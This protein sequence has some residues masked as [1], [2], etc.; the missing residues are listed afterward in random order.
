MSHHRRGVRFTAY[1]LACAAVVLMPAS[2]TATGQLL[3]RLLKSAGVPSADKPNA[4]TRPAETEKSHADEAETT[5][6]STQPAEPISPGAVQSIRPGTFEIHVRDADLR[7]VLQ[8]LSTQGRKNIIATRQVA[9]TVTA[10]LYGVTFQEAL[11]AILQGSGYVHVVKGNFIY[12]HTP[13]ELAAMKAAEREMTVKLF[14]LYYITAADAKALIAPVLSE[15]GE[16][17]ITPAAAVGIATSDD[18]AGGNSYGS[19]DVIIVREY[20]DKMPQIEKLIAQIDVKPEQVLIEATIL[21]ATLD[22][23]NTLGVDF[24]MLAGIDF[25]TMNSS[26][27]GLQSVSTGT[28]ATADLE[29]LR[30]ATFRSDFNSAIS[31]G[32]MTIGFLANDVGFFIRALE[33]VTDTT[34]LANPK[35]LVVNKQ[36]GEI[37]VGKNEGYITTTFVN[38]VATQTV[39]FLETGTRLVVRPF[40]GK[41]GYVRMEIHPKDSSGSLTALGDSYLPTENETKVTTNVFVRDGHTIVIGGLFREKTKNSRAQWPILGDVPYLG[42]LFR[43]TQD[44]LDREEVII[45]LTPHIIQQEA[46]EAVSEQ[47]KDDVERF[48][49]GQRKGLRWWGRNRI[50]QTYLRDAKRA[51]ADGRRDKALWNVD[52]ALSLQPRMEE[53][54]RLKERLTER[55]YW[56]D[57]SQYSSV[58]Y[59]I[60]RMIMQDL[61]K[62]VERIIPPAKPRLA[63][64]VEPEVRKAM[65][66][67]PRPEDPLPGPNE[68][69]N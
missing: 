8:L 24:N 31:S 36:R 22:E 43:R 56:S 14:R 49:V 63:E 28:I 19:E 1:I 50:A 67:E 35:L 25:E 59:I 7:G 66:V 29:G 6:P 21:A 2:S 61:G 23:D 9:G 30:G 15:A 44:E 39:E 51:L 11:D 13:E 26:S 18:E 17:S 47:I 38:E 42:A 32:G 46:D 54:I 57:Q 55:A 27:S 12:V 69:G 5:A 33:S 34:V 40:V 4:Q 3:K 48:R 68:E 58:K 16:I 20:K 53:A 52:M 45:L 10:D 64:Q 41:D 65:G 60:Q 37:W 62:P